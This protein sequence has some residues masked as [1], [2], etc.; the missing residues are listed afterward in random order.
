[1]W[2]RDWGIADFRLRI[3]DCGIG[4]QIPNLKHQIP[5]KLQFPKHQIQNNIIWGVRVLGLPATEGSNQRFE[6]WI[7]GF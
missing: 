5:N 4:R 1:M 6:H 2:S 3:V 7:L